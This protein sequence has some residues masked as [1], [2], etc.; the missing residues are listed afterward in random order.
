MPAIRRDYMFS[1]LY[2]PSPELQKDTA[3]IALLILL[4]L[5]YRMRQY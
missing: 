5:R 1:S 3:F 4:L 2:L